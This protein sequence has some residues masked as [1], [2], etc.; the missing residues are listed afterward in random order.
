[1]SDTKPIVKAL[2]EELKQ[3][4]YIVMVP[5]EVDAHG[6]IAT[7]EEVRKACY[8]FNKEVLHAGR[9]GAN[10]FHT[11]PTT[12]FEFAESYVLPVD[13]ELDGVL[14]TKG[15]WVT[16]LQVIDDELWG[17]IKSGDICGVS[18]SAIAEV[19]KLGE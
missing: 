4:L 11:Q 6:D 8:S 2:Q 18:I 12:S 15:T 17:F 7:V 10:L 1:M 9:P 16:T 5:D 13:I 14:V 19:Q 3:V